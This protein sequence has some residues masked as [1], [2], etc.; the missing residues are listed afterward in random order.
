MSID[1]EIIWKAK[2]SLFDTRVD[3]CEALVRDYC[4]GNVWAM[5]MFAE[6]GMWRFIY[7]RK[8]EDFEV[9]VQRMKTATAQ[10]A[11]LIKRY[12]CKTDKKSLERGTENALN[13]VEAMACEANSYLGLAMLLMI[14]KS[15]VKGAYYV[16]KSWKGWEATNKLLQDLKSANVKVPEQVEGLISFGVGKR[17]LCLQYS[18]ACVFF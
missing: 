15:F 10:A 1:P 6:A 4:Q 14:Q 8:N 11:V 5:A 3:D 17:C 13:Y 16:R 18:Y 2:E 9:A 12:K 7:E